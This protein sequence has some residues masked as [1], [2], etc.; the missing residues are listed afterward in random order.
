MLGGCHGAKSN[1][2]IGAY[3]WFQDGNSGTLRQ[4]VID[5]QTKRVAELVVAQGFLQRD[6]HVIPVSCV[7]KA[8]ADAISLSLQ[9]GD[10]VNYPEYR[11]VELTKSCLME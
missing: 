4:V 11:E 7:K 2:T 9:L 10:L 1:L 8:T 6:V 3:V 5:P